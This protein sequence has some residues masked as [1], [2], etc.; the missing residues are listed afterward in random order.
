M[1]DQYTLLLEW[2]RSEGATRG[3]AKLP[4]DFYRSTSAYLSEV[5]KTFEDELRENPSGRKGELARQTH[6]RAGQIAR[7][8]VEARMT[9]VLS[10][11]FQ[12]SIGGVKELPNALPEERSLFDALVGVL[13]SHRSSAA[14][15]LE[16]MGPSAPSGPSAPHPAHREATAG[17]PAPIAPV[18]PAMRFVRILQDSRPVELGTETIE[19]R[20]EDLLN[21][22][23]AVAQ[24]LIDGKIAEPVETPPAR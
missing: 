11:A 19:L 15:F 1:P 5:R 18:G 22:P 21:L 8:I 3:L 16:P 6:Q 2:R 10:Q 23:E 14:P 12:A 9:K 4:L 7:D 24:I 17:L 20:K 13:R